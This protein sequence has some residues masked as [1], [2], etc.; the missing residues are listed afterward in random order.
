M[1]GMDGQKLTVHRTVHWQP[2]VSK[3]VK[4]SMA[5]MDGNL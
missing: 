2:Y 3:E 5:G 1:D 4:V